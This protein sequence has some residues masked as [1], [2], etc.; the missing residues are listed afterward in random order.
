MAPDTKF[1]ITFTLLSLIFLEIYVSPTNQTQNAP[2]ISN[3]PLTALQ[4]EAAPMIIKKDNI[5]VAR[6]EAQLAKARGEIR[7][8]I[9]QRSF[10]SNGSSGTMYRNPFSFYQSHS[11]MMKT[12][13]VWTYKEG[14]IPLMHNGP[15]KSIYSSEGL[16]IEEIERKGNPVVANHP[17]EAHA[18]FIPISIC[19][20]VRYLFNSSDHP[21]NFLEKIQHIVED[22]IG[23]IAERYPYWNR[24]NGADH[25]YVS[26]H[27]WGPFASRGNP[28]LF[29]NLIRVL[30]NANSSEGFVPMRDVSMT[31]INGPFNSIPGVSSGQ[32]PNNRS[33]LA[34]FAGG[35]HGYVRNKLFKYW[36]NKEDNDI[37]VHTYLQEGQN[38]TKLI[39]E[40]KATEAI[41]VGCIPVIIK[42][43]YVL[44]YSD[45]LDWSQ[46]SV[47][48]PLDKIPDLKRILEDISF[49]KY[50]EMQKRL[51]EV[52]RHFV[53]NLPSKPFDVFHMILHSVWLRRLNV[54]FLSS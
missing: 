34:F 5:Q 22:Y 6:I 28:K 19:N 48:V 14:D 15:M 54:R 18:F 9:V 20:I 21:Y 51:M 2:S 13:K 4:D 33:I 31:E 43:H 52:Q 27:D 38:Y 30:C 25:F 24:T 7:K 41:Y 53:V 10:A 37:Q 1:T 36:G 47:E 8:S 11:E 39:T 50:L 49:T 46:F 23:V 29:K 17:D 3:L 40:S 26:C 42:D 44:P 32:S 16:F 35:N 12:F 45:V